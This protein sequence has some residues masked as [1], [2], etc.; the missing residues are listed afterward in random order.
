MIV[1]GADFVEGMHVGVTADLPFVV[2][3]CAVLVARRTFS[4]SS[5]TTSCQ[6]KLFRLKL[7]TSRWH[8]IL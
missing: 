3:Y 8:K 2:V 1:Q 5:L 7:Q 6:G 4:G